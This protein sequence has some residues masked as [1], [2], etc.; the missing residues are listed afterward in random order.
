MNLKDLDQKLMKDPKYAAY[1]K[2]YDA[3]EEKIWQQF[4]KDRKEVDEKDA[5]CNCLLD[6]M[7][8]LKEL[9]DK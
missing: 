9:K 8:E 7:F 2:D 3:L 1:S 6:F 5:F 4:Q